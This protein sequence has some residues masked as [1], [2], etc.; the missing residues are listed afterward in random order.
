MNKEI[1]ENV[2]E[3]FIKYV[4]SM[5]KRSSDRDNTALLALTY[6]NFEEYFNK[7]KHFFIFKFS[8]DD[9]MFSAIIR[10][11][12]MT[13]IAFI[14]RRNENTEME[15][16]LISIMKEKIDENIDELKSIIESKYPNIYQEIIVINT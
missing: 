8:T 11:Y 5:D 13:Q 7:H 16:L 1:L 9:K 6:D 2:Y 15:L 4:L 10:T 12:C 14:T 3:N